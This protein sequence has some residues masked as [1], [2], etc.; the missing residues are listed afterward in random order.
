MQK[1]ARKNNKY[2][3]IKTN[4]KI[5]RRRKGLSPCKMQNGQFGSKIEIVKNWKWQK[6]AKN[7]STRTSELFCAKNREK[8]TKYSRIKTNLKIS[9]LSKS[10]TPWKAYSLCKTVYLSQKLKMS[11]TC[12]KRF[13][14]NNRVILC[15]KPPE[16]NTKYW[17]IASYLKIS[18]RRKGYSPCK[19]FS[20]WKMVSLGQKVKRPKTSV[21][22]LYKN[23]RVVLC[24][25]TAWKN[26]KYS[27]FETNLNISAK[28]IAHAN[29]IAIAKWSVW[30]KN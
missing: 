16:K 7:N 8:N 6:R 27:R 15:K 17:R 18:L 25:K 19:G 9:H 21:K 26:T 30:V 13:Y 20:L 3:R 10:Y 4:L 11:K 29:V 23:M 22:R 2:S 5:S 24:K 14:K 1:T 28:A 12:G